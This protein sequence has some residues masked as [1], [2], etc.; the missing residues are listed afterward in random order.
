VTKN[1]ED[2]KEKL[3]K[4]REA[5]KKE[6]ETRKETILRL[7]AATA[8]EIETAKKQDEILENTRITRSAITIDNENEKITIDDL[9]PSST[10]PVALGSRSKRA[11]AGTIDYRTLAGLSRTREEIER[12][13]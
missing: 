6:K 8:L 9:P 3:R 5:D 11:R 4:A 7:H 13:N 2:K 10:A 12:L 1:R